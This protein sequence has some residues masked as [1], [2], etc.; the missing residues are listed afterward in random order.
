MGTEGCRGRDVTEGTDTGLWGQRHSHGVR[1]AAE[2][3]GTCVA[4][5]TETW[6]SEIET[7]L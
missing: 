6:Q 7:V 1:D 4:M 5:G 2:G 3:M